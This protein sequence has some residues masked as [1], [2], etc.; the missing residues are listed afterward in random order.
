MI[1]SVQCKQRGFF[2]NYFDITAWNSCMNFMLLCEN[3]QKSAHMKGKSEITE[4]ATDHVTIEC[5]IELK[6]ACV[7]VQ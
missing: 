3:I 6:S 4:N 2:F 7:I 5:E 1:T